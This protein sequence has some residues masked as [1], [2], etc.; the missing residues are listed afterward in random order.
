M[1]SPLGCEVPLTEALVR[2]S[3]PLPREIVTTEGSLCGNEGA[4]VLPR[5]AGGE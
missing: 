3:L 2:L 1:I 4:C 5:R